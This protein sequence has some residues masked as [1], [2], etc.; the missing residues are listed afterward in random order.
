M[1]RFNRISHRTPP[2]RPFILLAEPANR[3]IFNIFA[4]FSIFSPYFQYFRHIFNNPRGAATLWDSWVVTSRHLS[5]PFHVTIQTT[6]G[7]VWLFC[8]CSQTITIL[9]IGSPACL[10]NSVHS[11][12][13]T[14]SFGPLH[15]NLFI[16]TSSFAVWPST[17]YFPSFI[18]STKEPFV[19]LQIASFTI[20]CDQTYTGHPI[21]HW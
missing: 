19:L 1:D 6:Y 5:N 8:Y 11:D 2:A 15:L 10:L 21:N 20:C 9:H 4:I 17:S 14:S 12:T 13:W 18:R 16:W 3:H 7:L